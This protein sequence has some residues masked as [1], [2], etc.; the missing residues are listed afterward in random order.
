MIRGF[1]M[2]VIL[3]ALAYSAGF[4]L[5]VSLLPMTPDE[6]PKADGIVV[7]TGGGTRLDRAEA[8]FEHG[9]GKRLLIS[10]VDQATTKETLKHIMHGGPRFD[11]CADLGY[12]AEDTRGNAQETKAWTQA[13]DFH[14][15][16]LVTA[17][18]H[19]PRSL[20]EFSAAM[21]DVAFTPYPVEQG[22]IDLAGWWHYPKTVLLLHREYVKYLASLVTTSM[23]RA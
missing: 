5:F 12:A 8:L 15:L 7:L 10:G 2:A 13:H 22:R 9:V 14:S 16:L 23:A 19:M 3:V 18:Y 6:V 21:P 1:F 17:R 11:C 4:V 20:Q